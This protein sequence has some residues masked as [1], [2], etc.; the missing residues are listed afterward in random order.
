MDLY[1][2]LDHDFLL[3]VV[4]RPLYIKLDTAVEIGLTIIQASS[5]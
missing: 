2:A 5:K 3:F 1:V 4:A